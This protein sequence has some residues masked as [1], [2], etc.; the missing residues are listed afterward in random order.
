LQYP[1]VEDEELA[2]YAGYAA[3]LKKENA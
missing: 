1:K 3:E 2:K